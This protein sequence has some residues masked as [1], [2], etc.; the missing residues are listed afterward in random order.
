MLS[1]SRIT[2]HLIIWLL[3][4]LLCFLTPLHAL[5]ADSLV[6]L[7]DF[8]PS[9]NRVLTAIRKH[10]ARSPRVVTLDQ[11][12]TEDSR[13]PIIL[14]VGTRACERML[15]RYHPQSRL[16][17]TFLPSAT[18][19]RLK[20]ELLPQNSYA[21]VSAVFIDQPLSRQIRLAR[22]IAP[23]A[24]ILGSALGDNSLG[25]RQ[26]LQHSAR[27]ENFELLMVE[28]AQRDN[29]VERLTPVI[30]GCDLFLVI[31]DSSVFNRAISKWLLY[32]AL[33]HK[34]PVIGFSASYTSAG[35]TASVHSSPEQIGQQSAEWLN[36]LQRGGSLPP[37]SYP[38]YFDVSVNPIAVRTLDIEPLSADALRK[39][40]IRAEAGR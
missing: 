27:V 7:S 36:L 1:L 8:S 11:L 20:Q 28:L 9:Y 12:R 30:E 10:A 33:R 2:P 19:K 21:A 32:L 38:Y 18:F 37:A 31:P 39:E 14:A 6:V 29:P 13:T 26:E 3:S 22:L 17:C 15:S 23:E 34:I 16:I 4:G 5:A 25:L 40:L 35:A 24:S